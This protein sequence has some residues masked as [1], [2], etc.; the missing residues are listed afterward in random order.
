LPWSTVVCVQ[1]TDD[2]IHRFQELWREEFGEEITTD[3]AREQIA[4]LDALYLVLYGPRR[5]R[6]NEALAESEATEP[7]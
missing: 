2:D 1:I 3:E 5:R 7:Q 4:R 6:E